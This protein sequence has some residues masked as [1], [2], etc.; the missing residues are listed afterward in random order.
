MSMVKIKKRQLVF[1]TGV[2]E[3]NPCNYITKRELH[4]GLL[5]H[6]QRMCVRP[7]RGG[8]HE[9]LPLFIW[10]R[11]ASQLYISYSLQNTTRD[12]VKIGQPVVEFNPG[13][14]ISVWFSYHPRNKI[15]TPNFNTGAQNF[16][17]NS[18][19]PGLK[20]SSQY[21]LFVYI[22]PLF[23]LCYFLHS[24]IKLRQAENFDVYCKPFQPGQQGI[25]QP[26]G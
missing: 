21:S 23:S 7:V 15:T 22:F 6:T 24:D 2:T 1:V 18:L 13:V 11:L 8:P 17:R 16:S 25:T 20:S 14:E 19:I 4:V 26:L 5:S 12:N 9:A 3:Q 10:L